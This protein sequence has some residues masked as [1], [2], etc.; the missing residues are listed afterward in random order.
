[1]LPR[2]L[3]QGL[4]AHLRRSGGVAAA[5]QLPVVLSFLSSTV[6]QQ[7]GQQAGTWASLLRAMDAARADVQA[8]VQVRSRCHPDRRGWPDASDG[9]WVW[10]SGMLWWQD[11]SDPRHAAVKRLLSF[12]Q[13]RAHPPTALSRLHHHQPAIVDSWLASHRW[14]CCAVVLHAEPRPPS[15]PAAPPPPHGPGQRVGRTGGGAAG[16]ED[17]GRTGHAPQKAQGRQTG[18][19]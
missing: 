3:V 13:V 11:K 15:G 10:M 19:G 8:I 4:A 7:G 1:M 18:T 14:P 17:D 12:L 9:P 5:Q 6:L 16:T 2:G